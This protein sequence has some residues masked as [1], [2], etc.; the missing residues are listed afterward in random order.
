M[1]KRFSIVIPV[2]NRPQEVDELLESL[3]PFAPKIEVVIVEDGSANRCDEVVERYRSM[4]DVK[5]Y[6]KPNSGPGTTRNYGAERSEGEY[7]IFFDSDCIVPQGYFDAVEQA[8][9]KSDI[10]A[11]GGPDRA[12]E[13]FT[14][15]QKS[16]NYSM[17]SF[18]TTGG[19]RGRERSVEKFSP[20]S[21]NM[22]IRR[23]V[24][25]AIGG[26][27]HLRFGED[28]DLSYRIVEGGYSTALIQ[29]AW[30]YHKRRT[31]FKQFFKQIFNSGT[32]RV[33]LSSRHR[34]TL[35]LVHMLPTL[36]VLFGVFVLGS[37]FVCAYALLLPLLL[38]VLIFV[39]STLR[40]RSLSIGALSIVSSMVQL[41][42]YGVGFL[43]G[44]WRVVILRS[45]RYTAFEKKFYD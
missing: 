26:F 12:H 13:S 43:F 23:S 19:I 33:V 7:I 30:V 36:M 27:S 11:F 42:A 20:R 38:F 15:T 10:D 14:L 29:D 40:N 3:V 18:L 31:N 8:L 28:I 35:K 41:T 22:G 9:A 17:T 32:A 39:D 5:Y 25:E 44:V 16:I 4:L 1:T 34:G 2:Y 37:A 21:F 45:E 24:F 6:F